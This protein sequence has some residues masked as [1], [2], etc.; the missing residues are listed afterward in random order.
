[1]YQMS[2]IWLDAIGHRDARFDPLRLDLRG[3][4]G[5]SVLDTI[6][7]LRNMGGKSSLLALLF[8]LFQPARNE[9][10][11]S[12]V[13]GST[14]RLEDYVQLDDVAHVMVEWVRNAEGVL[15]G[16]ELGPSLVTGVVMCWRR[17]GGAPALERTFY[18][19]HPREGVLELD[20][21]RTREGGRRVPM[22]AF[23]D[24][25][26]QAGKRS[27]GLEVVTTE[28]QGEWLDYLNSAGID[29][30]KF[31]YQLRMN[32]NEGGADEFLRFRDGDE[33]VDFLIELVTDPSSITQ[34]AD[35]LGQVADKLRLRPAREKELKLTGG[36]VMR[37]RPLAEAEEALR[38]AQ[39]AQVETQLAGSALLAR[40]V[41]SADAAEE[42]VDAQ[43]A[44]AER[45]EAR[46][47]QAE[48]Q[49]WAVDR[50]SNTLRRRLAQARVQAAETALV[51]A[52]K[53]ESEAD[54]LVRAWDLAETR[55]EEREVRGQVAAL[56]EAVARE[57]AGAED[58]RQAYER[59]AARYRGALARRA[60]DAESRAVAHRAAAFEAR[61]AVAAADAELQRVNA[62]RAVATDRVRELRTRAAAADERL[63][64]VRSAGLLIAG[65]KAATALE[66]V[67]QQA[68]RLHARTQAIAERQR[69]L[70][71]AV[72]GARGESATLRAQALRVEQALHA[73]HVML[74]DVRARAGALEAEERTRDIAEQNTV[75]LFVQGG[76][77]IERLIHGVAD[78]ERRL[79]EMEIENAEHRRAQASLTENRLLPP[80]LEVE[81]AIARLHEQSVPATSGWQYLAEHVPA[82]RRA[83]LFTARPALADAVIV[84][85]GVLD[86]AVELLLGAGGALSGALVVAES[87]AFEAPLGAA[88]LDHWRV[89][90]PQSAQYDPAH[91]A[92]EAATRASLLEDA[93]GEQERIATQRDADRRLLERIRL[94]LD[95]YPA[96]RVA[97][98][99]SEIAPQELER[100]RLQ[101]ALRTC[102]DREAA[103]DAERRELEEESSRLAADQPA[104]AEARA[105]LQSVAGLED[106]REAWETAATEHAVQAQR[107]DQQ[108]REAEV[109]R[110]KAREAE[111]QER[112]NA[113]QADSEAMAWA[114]EAAKVAQFDAVVAAWDDLPTLQAAHERSRDHYQQRTTHSERARE[115]ETA[116]RRLSVLHQRLQ[117]EATRLPLVDELL[118]GPRGR[119]SGNRQAGREAAQH[120]YLA[121]VE[122]RVGAEAVLSGA[123]DALSQMSSDRRQYL[124]P[125]PNLPTATPEE[126]EE[127][128]TRL[129]A[130]SDAYGRTAEEAA[131]A[132]D[133]AKQAV[134]AAGREKERLRLHQSHLRQSLGSDNVWTGP[135]GAAITAEA[136]LTEVA[137]A[138]VAVTERASQVAAATDRFREA[139]IEIRRFATQREFDELQGPLLGRFREGTEVAIA[140]A[141]SADADALEVRRAWIEKDL[142]EIE[143][144]R[145][146]VALELVALVNTALHNLREAQKFRL[147][148]GLGDWSAT[149]YLQI[150]FQ[151]PDSVDEKKARLQVLIDELI[152]AGQRPE[153]LPLL[154]KGVRKVNRRGSFEVRVLKPNDALRA[155]RAS[156]VEIGSWSGGQKLT[157]AILIYC[158][159]TWLRSRNR[160][161]KHEQQ[162]D[163][164]IL[165][166]PIGK[167][168]HIALVDLQRKVAAC[169]RIQL[170]Y[171]TGLDDKS[172]IAAFPNVI[173]LRNTKDRRSGN[174]Y[175]RPDPLAPD[176]AMADDNTPAVGMVSATRVYRRGSERATPTA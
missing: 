164:L 37:L 122:A 93:A 62:E 92:D 155:E 11:G 109:L 158:V 4:T 12:R 123:Q 39:A 163:V 49:Q 34:V 15:P 160:K 157:T 117:G 147:P 159:L 22:R 94:L 132:R 125:P 102:S 162:A 58:L 21:L 106:E 8:A 69:E 171:T 100:D 176:G 101:A 5:H 103:L 85:P 107:L 64:S 108:R 28:K 96:S 73:A 136:A 143:Q 142:A 50:Q 89:L 54:A 84:N 131:A 156:V 81:R 71:A 26:T 55:A 139:A 116:R 87:L 175:V 168:N 19:F 82:E 75:D 83:T 165:D 167:A 78:Q 90:P 120:G 60:A 172:A 14:K 35:N 126:L 53:I 130:A 150:N 128:R 42:R 105:R 133:A 146:T 166:N 32:Q 173:R 154:L 121:A 80:R 66:R 148:D 48:T 36:L 20:R 9:F 2:R 18:A 76:A 95:E 86:R 68:G 115:L 145:E 17:A 134:E 52:R 161:G 41:A 88:D 144:H 174:G 31:R 98:I 152:Q 46:R 25:I 138:A 72:Q 30:E 151:A 104:R 77:I 38:S 7:W 40:I 99:E 140:A 10:L 135:I 149:P 65:E 119:T 74:D 13:R 114:T 33:F 79:V 24:Q 44:E 47:A 3:D 169:F 141:A 111:Q 113:T 51:G 27:A 23:L 57:F 59:D 97:L 61:S 118:D 170:I 29:A 43:T 91:A 56:E 1:M 16:F 67:I 129:Q 6:V 63:E 45:Q 112:E 127:S 70:H 137:A 110:E 124:D 153:G